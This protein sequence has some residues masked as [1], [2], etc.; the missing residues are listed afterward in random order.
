MRQSRL[1]FLL[2]NIAL[3]VALALAA[4]PVKAETP[5]AIWG[6]LLKTYVSTPPDGINRFDYAHV[7]GT[8]RNRLTSYLDQ[9]QRLDPSQMPDN[10]QRAYWINL[11]NA[12]TVKVVLDHYPVKSIRDI[13]SGFFSTGP[14]NDE[15]AHVAGENLSLNNIEHD[16]LR[17]RW[18][19]N[20][21]HY[22]LNCASLGCPNLQPEPFTAE[23]LNG[24]LDQAARD[25]VN[26]PRG[27]NI[28]DG[29]LT[30]SSIYKWYAEDFGNNNKSV[31]AHIASFS[32]AGRAAR[33][34][35]MSEIDAYIYDWNLNAPEP[36]K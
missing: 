19:D 29:K 18:K 11:Y 10:E 30:V 2:R 23:R 17:K 4:L 8:D 24:Q 5:D 26:H 31:I 32:T 20:R 6:D 21:I 27:E 16:I 3:I 13:R 34:S 1:P 12:L 35:D 36:A 9:M 14:W 15:L 25:Y 7:S 22:A 33:L 28:H